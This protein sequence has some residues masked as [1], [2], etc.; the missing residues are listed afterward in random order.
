MPDW[1]PPWLVNFLDGVTLLDAALWVA[2]IAGLLLVLRKVGPWFVAFARAVLS[3]VTL[4]DSVKGL[5]AF[6]ERTDKTLETQ[7]ETLDAHG[8][9]L[10]VQDEKIADIHHETHTNN[11]S[12]IKDAVVRVEEVVNTQI[13]PALKSLATAGTELR[14]DFEDA[15]NSRVGDPPDG[16]AQGDDHGNQL[17]GQPCP[18]P[19]SPTRATSASS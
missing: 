7:N 14:Q 4:I 8:K 1:M 12:S 9:T 6:I 3:T 11:G 13:L 15:Q 10:A 18:T 17:G 5:P 2:V 19:S 16:H